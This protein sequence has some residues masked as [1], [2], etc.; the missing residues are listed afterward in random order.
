L[1]IASDGILADS[2]YVDITVTNVNRAPVLDPITSPQTVAEGDSLL[3]TATAS[4]VDLT[5]PLLTAEGLPANAT[6]FDN[7]DGTG[8]FRFD[9][10]YFQ[11]GPYQVLF[12]ASDGDLADSQYVDITVTNTNRAPVLDPITSPQFV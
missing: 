4:D 7:G 12:I 8:D 11:A 10:N 5:T 9:P 2:Q 3:F 1:F 6:F